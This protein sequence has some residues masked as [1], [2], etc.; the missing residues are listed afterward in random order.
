[1]IP[2]GIEV[3]SGTNLTVG[4]LLAGLPRKENSKLHNIHMITSSNTVSALDMAM[5]MVD[6]LLKLDSGVFFSM[7]PCC[8]KRW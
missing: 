5:P 3:R 1:M 4:A 6:E 2:A 8:N 7:M